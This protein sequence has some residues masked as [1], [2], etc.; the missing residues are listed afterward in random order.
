MRYLLLVGETLQPAPQRGLSHSPLAP[1]DDLH[2]V[3]GACAVKLAPEKAERQGVGSTGHGKST[4]SH[5]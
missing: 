5:G 3:L 2:V 1:D 4:T